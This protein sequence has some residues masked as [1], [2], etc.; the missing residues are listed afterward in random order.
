MGWWRAWTVS[1]RS[2]TIQH[3]VIVL[4]GLCVGSDPNQ[5]TQM[6]YQLTRVFG[7]VLGLAWSQLNDDVFTGTPTSR[8]GGDG[9]VAADASDRR[10]LREL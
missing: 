6:Q 5:L 7:R 2:G 3:A 9:D 10:D 1:D 4:N 8:G